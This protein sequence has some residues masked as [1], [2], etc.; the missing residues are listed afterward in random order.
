MFLNISKSKEWKTLLGYQKG[1]SIYLKDKSGKNFFLHPDGNTNPYL[2]LKTSIEEMNKSL[3][4][5]DTSQHPICRFPSRFKYLRKK[6][7]LENDI[8]SLKKCS[9][10]Q[11]WIAQGKIQSVSLYFA[12]G[13][14][15][16]PASYFGHPFIKF[17]LDTKTPDLV[18]NTLNFGAITPDSENPIIYVLYGLF[19]GYRASFSSQAF[20]F[21]DHN[22]GNTE[23]RDLWEYELNLSPK[24]VEKLVDRSWELLGVK[25][26]YLFL[27]KNCASQMAQLLEEVIGKKLYFRNSLYVIPV[28]IFDNL[29]NTK[30]QKNESYVKNIKLRPSKQTELEIHYVDLNKQEVKLLKKLINSPDNTSGL[31]TQVNLDSQIRVLDTATHYYSQQ[32]LSEPDKVELKNLR[33][34]MMFHRLKIDSSSKK[35]TNYK[36]NRQAPHLMSNSFRLSF[37]T[38]K[39]IG[40]T[41]NPNF[42]IRPALYDELN[43]TPRQQ[44]H[45]SLVVFDTH[46]TRNR[47][48]IILNQLDIF[49]ISSYNTSP[50]ALPGH[51]EASWKANLSI[52][53]PTHFCEDCRSPEFSYSYGI[54]HGGISAKL[55]ALAGLGLNENIES[56]GS[57]FVKP[58]IG[59]FLEPFKYWKIHLNLNRKQFLNANKKSADS[60]VLSQR[61]GQDKSWDI[62]VDLFFKKSTEVYLG[63]NIYL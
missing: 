43:L 62:D 52:I 57:L 3:E 6:V 14:F 25:Q 44:K 37:G 41:P 46:F 56:S 24:E 16:N 32:L 53:S 19:G 40:S 11:K 20:Y 45:S 31:L 17:N 34:K 38:S 61:W 7:A 49:R 35:K 30:N 10:Y 63:L 9:N 5:G 22:Y 55:Y 21:H 26:S 4:T 12:S 13:Y 51:P 59:F 15:G 23:M 47:K 42:R 50:V 60:L 1:D 33:T 18:Q 58:E 27:S 8:S 28:D 2:E 39:E 29:K 48:N 36:D 54:S